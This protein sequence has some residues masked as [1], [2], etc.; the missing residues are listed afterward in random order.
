MKMQRAFAFE[1]GFVN[2]LL[3]FVLLFAVTALTNAFAAQSAAQIAV[4]AAKKYAGTTITVEWQAGLQALDPLNFSGPLWERLTGIKIKVVEVPL[5]EVF[6]KI[7]LDYR[8]GSGGFDVVDVVPSWMPDLAQ[9]GA[10]EP[11][12]AYVDRY[13]YRDELNK[14]APTFRDNWTRANGRIYAFPD[15]GDVLI[16][17]YRKDIFGDA[18]IKSAFKA[19]HGYEL[20]PPKTWKQFDEIGSFLTENLKREGVY[21]ASSVRDPAFAQYMFQERF[22]NEGGKFFDADTMKATINSPIGTHVLSEMRDENRFMPPGVETFKFA[23]NLAIFQNGESAMTISWPPV[24]R[25]AAGYGADEKALAFVPKSKIAGKVG[26]AL[27]P[28]GHPELAIGHALSVASTS[29]NKEAAYLFIQWLNSEETSIKRVQL[30]YTLRD[31]FRTSHYSNPEYRSKW[32]DAKDYLDTLKLASEAGLF[33]LSLIQTDKYE[34]VL[35]QGFSRLWAGEDAKKILDDLARQW[36]ELTE[37]VGVERQR[38]VYSAWT[39]KP[40]AY[41]RPR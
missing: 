39:A 27:P 35:R 40:G 25:W 11:L 6:S 7:M 20:A 17:Y 31:P 3:Q 8:S 21:G 28:G 37:R 1:R 41:P 16:L 38:A 4:D 5:A 13:G 15:D 10:L 24:G 36:D 18:R 14:I 9:A 22:R 33:D 32:P 19:K 30:P 23:E 12:D 29:R 2:R 26:Y 34:E